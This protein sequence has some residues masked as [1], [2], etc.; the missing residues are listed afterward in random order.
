MGMGTAL[1]AVA[2]ALAVAAIAVS[3]VVPGPAG[4]T[5]PTGAQGTQGTQ[6]TQGPQGTQGIQGPQG[7]PGVNGTN[8]STGPTGP[9]GPAGPAGLNLWAVVN[10]NGTL[11]YANGATNS[12]AIFGYVGTYEVDFQQNVTQCSYSASLGLTNS[13]WSP[14]A[15]S[16]TV[17]SRYLNPDGVFVQTFDSSGNLVSQPF[18]LSVACNW[19]IWAVVD[20]NGTLVRG[21]AAV[22]ASNQSVGNYL[23]Y[24]NQDVQNCSFF[25]TVGT[26]SFGQA[27][28]GYIT[29]AG[30]AINQNAVWVSTYNDSGA[31]VAQAFHLS[32]ECRSS[33]WA[34]VSSSG[35]LVRGSSTGATQLF[36]FNGTYEVDFSVDVQ[37][38]AVIVD[39][40]TT[41][42]S[43]VSFAGSVST[44]GR[45]G[46]DMGVFVETFDAS[47]V[48]TND[49]FHIAVYC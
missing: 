45:S 31:N 23:V 40:G 28:P 44:A 43:G 6:G 33:A 14:Y 5:G 48:L 11:A 18:H 13:T 37:N 20:Q 25:G 32:V 29:V 30:A 39:Q 9:A 12:F 10:T 35:A 36:G 19:G 1:A 16:V 7:V 22:N 17:A 41:G 46:N 47:G 49:S 27:E 15:G 24:F 4:P 38:C 2:I 34:V 21:S 3:F 8:G 26:T 42:S